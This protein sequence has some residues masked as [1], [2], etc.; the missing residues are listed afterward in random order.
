MDRLIKV[1]NGGS[2]PLLLT[3]G[4][5]LSLVT[6]A[7]IRRWAGRA[8]F[9]P[10][11]ACLGFSSVGRCFCDGLSRVISPTRKRCCYSPLP[12]SL[13][14]PPVPPNACFLSSSSSSSYS[15]LPSP[16]STSLP[17]CPLSTVPSCKF[18][19]ITPICP[20]NL[21]QKRTA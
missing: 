20:Y 15:L 8:A 16:P 7:G 6:A 13:S 3:A 10:S 18:S 21:T 4:P 19:L 1:R 17:S 12:P 14:L 9:L 5:P 11:S 2:A